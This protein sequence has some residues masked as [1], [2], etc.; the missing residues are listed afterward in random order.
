MA[1]CGGSSEWQIDPGNWS[2]KINSGH[3]PV[4]PTPSLLWRTALV[5]PI[6]LPGTAHPRYILVAGV[7]PRRELDEK[8]LLF[9]DLLV[10]TITN[11]L[12]KARAYE[13]ERKRAEALAELDRAKTAFS[14]ISATNS[15]PLTLMLGPLEDSFS[16]KIIRFPG[17]NRR[18]WNLSTGIRFVCNG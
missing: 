2:W 18:G 14:A 4:V 11:T 8:Y 9:Y 17:N 5:L 7:S 3:F 15:A 16:I 1:L 13:E 6:Y 12:S 10:G